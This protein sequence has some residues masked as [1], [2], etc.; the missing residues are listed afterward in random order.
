MVNRFRTLLFAIG[1]GA[2]MA[3]STTCFFLLYLNALGYRVVVEEQNLVV[4]LGEM[5]LMVL[6]IGTC[7]AALDIYCRYFTAKESGKHV[8]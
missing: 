2:A 6:A 3:A 7:A 5:L 1:T 4:L 8:G